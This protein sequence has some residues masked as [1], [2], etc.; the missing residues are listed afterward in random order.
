M[1]MTKGKLGIIVSGG[2]ASG[3]N[4]V[5][6]SAAIEA[7]NIGI[8]VV[9]YRSGFRAVCD[10]SEDYLI[11][12]KTTNVTRIANTGGSILGVSRT[13]PWKNEQYI[14]RFKN[15]L[16]SHNIDKLIIIGGEGS[17]YLSYKISKEIPNVQVVHVPKTIDND[18]SLPNETPSFGFET[19]RYWGT[20]ILHTL[21]TDAKTCNRWFMATSMGRKAGYLALGIGIAS[22]ATLTL[23][24]E[25]FGSECPT[26]SQVADIIYTTIKRRIDAGKNYGVIVV[27]EGVLDKMDPTGSEIIEKCPRDEMGRIV[28]A[29]IELGDV[30]LPIIKQKC[31]DNGFEVR[32]NTKNIGYE[33]RCCEPVPFDIEY[34]KILGFGA[35]QHLKNGLTGVMVTKEFDRI[36]YVN[37]EDMLGANGKVSSRCVDLNSDVYRA[38]RCFMI[39]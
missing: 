10:G 21:A 13:N 33:L 36:G 30:L 4:G 31:R 37:L 19:A 6:S 8:E 17:A 23:I 12:L 5:I 26:P 28:Y 16:I 27:A 38:A 15:S 29:E 9:G 39:R 32:I 18:L 20:K 1:N 35:V 34:T 22:E 25:E 7:N 11:P 14:S 3:I 2:P 24:P